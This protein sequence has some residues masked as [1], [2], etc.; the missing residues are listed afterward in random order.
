MTDGTSR[1]M[2]FG[3]IHDLLR[4]VNGES[5]P[6]YMWQSDKQ[7]KEV[8]TEEPPAVQEEQVRDPDEKSD[9][10]SRQETSEEA[11]AIA[12]PEKVPKARRKDQPHKEKSHSSVSNPVKEKEPKHTEPSKVNK[13]LVNKSQSSF[14][15]NDILSQ[16][17]AFSCDTETGHRHWI[18]LP[19]DVVTTLEAV[20]GSHRISA[21]FTALARS[22]IDA[23]K[24]EL[25]RLVTHRSG[26]FE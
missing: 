24:E 19:T 20:Y 10:E 5:E 16:I 26:L 13:P 14:P 2:V 11:S 4:K 17:E 8:R 23:N 7:G 1:P 12:K 3:D 22:F 18:F 21:I 6:A 9:K 15:K 25:R